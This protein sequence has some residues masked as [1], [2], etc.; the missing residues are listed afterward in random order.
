MIRVSEVTRISE[1]NIMDTLHIVTNYF[2]VALIM[3]GIVFEM[4]GKRNNAENAITYG[5]N[6]VRLGMIFA[7]ISVLTGFASRPMIPAQSEAA[8]ASMFHTVISVLC[9]AL[10]LITIIIRS[11]FAKKI[12]D[13]EHGG[14]LSGMY[15]T[16]QSLC[17]ILIIATMLLGVRMVRTYGVGVKPVEIMNRLPVTPPSVDSAIKRDTTTYLQ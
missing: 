7:V 5:W 10:L 9:S 12:Y 17:L 1:K 15:T 16:L 3:L 13:K 2:T 4:L 14:F 6:T 8:T 11:I